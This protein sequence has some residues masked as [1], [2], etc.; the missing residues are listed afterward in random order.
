M[1][2]G[3]LAGLSRLTFD[4]NGGGG[5]SFIVGGLAAGPGATVGGA[6]FVDF[7]V[8]GACDSGWG[9]TFRV[10]GGGGI[11][12]ALLPSDTSSA[13]GRAPSTKRVVGRGPDDDGPLDFLRIGCGGGGLEE[14]GVG[15]LVL[16][17]E[18]F[19]PCSWLEFTGS[20]SDLS[21]TWR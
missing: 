8:E 21:Y 12:P 20:E 19:D 14:D 13:P 4:G 11:S 1:V 16:A 6:I 9:T 2:P 7:G 17:A 10:R 5:I 3:L 18:E 15:A